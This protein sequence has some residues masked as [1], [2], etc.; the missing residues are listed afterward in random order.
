[1]A[2]IGAPVFAK[3]SAC[4]EVAAV[5][6]LTG[7]VDEIVGAGELSGVGLGDGVSVGVGVAVGVGLG[8]V[9]GLGVGLGLEL[10]L[11]LGLE[12]GLGLGLELGLG[13]GLDDGD[14][15]GDGLGVG[16]AA[17][18]VVRE[19]LTAAASGV[20]LAAPS[21]NNDPPAAAATTGATTN[22]V[23]TS[24]RT[25][26]P[27]FPVV[28]DEPPL[29]IRPAVDWASSRE[30]ASGMLVSRETALSGAAAVTVTVMQLVKASRSRWSAESGTATAVSR[31]WCSQ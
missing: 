2:V 24:L 30:T 7:S 22:R 17:R 12:L 19:T 14:D 31:V 16:E 3:A 1:M 29:T 8:L 23:K 27:R 25:S 5:F 11:G 6:A 13:L 15:D 20:A 26:K 28:P 9:L 18:Y 10:G 21:T 4:E